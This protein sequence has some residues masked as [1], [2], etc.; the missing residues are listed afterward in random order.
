M[1][2]ARVWPPPS[3]TVSRVPE[4]MLPLPSVLNTPATAKLLLA[5]DTVDGEDVV[6]GEAGIGEAGDCFRQKV[7]G[8]R[9][10]VG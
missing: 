2:S 8:G 1:G 6:S 10:G 3:L 5:G 9:N 4:V 7:Q